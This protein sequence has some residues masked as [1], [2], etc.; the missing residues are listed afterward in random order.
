MTNRYFDRMVNPLGDTRRRYKVECCRCGVTATVN[1][2]TRTDLP[3]E[4][5]ERKLVERGWVVGK[6]NKH[7]L[8]PAHA[9]HPPKPI[10][11]IETPI[12]ERIDKNIQ[13]LE[14]S[15]ADYMQL[16]QPRQHERVVELLSQFRER[17]FGSG[18]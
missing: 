12:V 1:C 10:R 2:N 11:D 17:I 18:A 5:I 16:E 13:V 6:D 15:L 3:P 4:V 7:D 14:S 9:K 8:C